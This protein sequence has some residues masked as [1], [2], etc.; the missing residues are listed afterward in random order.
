MKA[1]IIAAGMGSRLWE[2]TYNVPKTLLPYEGGTILSKIMD[3]FCRVGIKDFV[4]VVGYHSHFIEDYLAG[5]EIATYRVAIVNNPEWEKGNGISVLAAA[6][7]VGRDSFILSMS[8]HVVS[9]EALKNIVAADEL[10][11][12]LLVDPDVGAIFDLDDATKVLCDDNQIIDIGKTI[13]KYNGID[14]G[15]FKLTGRFFV[16][17]KEALG[18]NEESISSAIKRLIDESDMKAVFLEPDDKWI[19]IDT[20]EAYRYC[21]DNIKL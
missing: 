16:K 10:N 18:Q 20:P 8:D 5:H 13:P 21:L 15:I 1:V 2:E 19:D 4:I 7:E 14:C 3:N 9:P 11:N 17:M 6:P 12:S